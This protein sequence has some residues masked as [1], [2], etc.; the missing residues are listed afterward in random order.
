VTGTPDGR[1]YDPAMPDRL[2]WRLI[3]VAVAVVVI[4]TQ[5]VFLLGAA[6]LRMSPEF[7][8][9]TTGLGALTAAFFLTASAASAPL[10]RVV[11]RIGWARAMRLN[12]VASGTLLLV[13]AAAARSLPVFAIL[14]VLSGIV[15]GLANPAANQALAEH[16]DPRRR[17]LVF[18]LKHAGIPSSTLVAG[19]ALPVVVLNAGWR[20]AYVL[21][22]AGAVAVFL[23][24]PGRAETRMVPV[25]ALTARERRRRVAPMGSALLVGLAAGAALATWAAISLSTYLVAAAVDRGFSEGAAGWLLFAGS[26]ASIAG[27]VA[28]GHVTDRIGGRGFGAVA[29]LTASGV[30]VFSLIAWLHGPMFA[31][32]VLVAF[33]TGWGWPG[34]MTYTVVNANAGTAAASSGITQ[35]GIFVGAGLGPI[36]LGWMAERFGFD[37]VWAAVAVAL[38]VATIVVAAVG[39]KATRVPLS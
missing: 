38:A 29:T 33:A 14:L 20:L 1:R 27:R 15:Y 31:T 10:G 37:V 13:I 6:F 25:P 21:A 17:A 34:L 7:G 18:G 12:V 16:V 4:S 28:A 23:L 39:R 11:Q 9:G 2:P 22:A 3:A 35:A 26:A 19:L 8:F 36:V 32:L 24:V 5:P 30:V